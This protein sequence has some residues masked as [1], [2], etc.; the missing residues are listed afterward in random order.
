MNALKP[1]E[2]GG[3]VAGV[4]ILGCL[5]GALLAALVTCACGGGAGGNSKAGASSPR[6]TDDIVMVSHDAQPADAGKV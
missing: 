3:L 5:G 2:I 4:L 6:A 1:A